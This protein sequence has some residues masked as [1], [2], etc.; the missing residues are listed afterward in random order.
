LASASAALASSAFLSASVSAVA[1]ALA[2]FGVSGVSFLSPTAAVVE[3]VLE[4]M[5]CVDAGFGFCTDLSSGFRGFLGTPSLTFLAKAGLAALN[6][7]V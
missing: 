2:S 3:M 1:S 7:L 5:G 6:V 4:I